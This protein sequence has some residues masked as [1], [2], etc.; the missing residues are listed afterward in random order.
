MMTNIFEIIQL[1]INYSF[2]LLQD[3]SDNESDYS[4]E[5]EDEED[6]LPSSESL[7][8]G[9]PA[10]PRLKNLSAYGSLNALDSDANEESQVVWHTFQKV[11]E[12]LEKL[13][14]GEYSAHLKAHPLIV[15]HYAT[16]ITEELNTCINHIKPFYSGE[17]GAAVLASLSATIETV[18]ACAVNSICTG[19]VEGIC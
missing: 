4:D 6:E 1:I 10:V 2:F 13:S 14:P 15:L 12:S 3:D 9:R 8:G 5:M 7:R 11:S 18:K 19:F 17:E 16:K